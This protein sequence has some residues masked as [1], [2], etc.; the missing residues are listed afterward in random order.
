MTN[1][2]FEIKKFPAHLDADE[3]KAVRLHEGDRLASWML[4][5]ADKGLGKSERHAP[6]PFSF[7]VGLHAAE[8]VQTKWNSDR[9]QALEAKLA[10]LEAKLAA[11]KTGRTKP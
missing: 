3:R 1:A 4:D 11:V 6:A 9:I 5:N 2:E 7:V 10:E 8:T